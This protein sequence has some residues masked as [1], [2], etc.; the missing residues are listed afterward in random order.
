MAFSDSFCVWRRGGREIGA[1]GRGWIPALTEPQAYVPERGRC[2]RCRHRRTPAAAAAK[3]VGVWKAA[4]YSQNA[5]FAN[6]KGQSPS[7]RKESRFANTWQFSAAF[8]RCAGA[9]T[10]LQMWKWKN[11][12]PDEKSLL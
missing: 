9:E 5:T 12:L 11:R 6:A 7:L 2:V 1:A 10:V 8:F 4:K 3:P